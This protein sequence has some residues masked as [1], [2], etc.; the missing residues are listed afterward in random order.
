MMTE[1]VHIQT[2][3]AEDIERAR[4]S[5][6]ATC[7]RVNAQWVPRD[8]IAEALLIEY[9]EQVRQIAFEEHA[10]HCLENAIALL[11]VGKSSGLPQ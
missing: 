5:I 9:M 1:Q 6:R 2:V 7:E 10:V 8:A 3:H 4:A 11:R